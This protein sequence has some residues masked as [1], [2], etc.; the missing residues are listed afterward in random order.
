MKQRLYQLA[1]AM[2]LTLATLSASAREDEE[3]ALKE[4]RLEGY[5]T[6]VKLP[7]GS[8]ALTW[9]CAGF[10]S[11]ITVATLLKNAKRTHLD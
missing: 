5:P 7:S 6:A 4:G 9:L 11:A 1:V 3:S 2:T 10:V 8:T